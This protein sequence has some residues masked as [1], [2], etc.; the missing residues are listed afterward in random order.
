VPKP[1]R[2]CA[3]REV[4]WVIPLC[5]FDGLEAE[6]PFFQMADINYFAFAIV[7]HLVQK[8]KGA[9]RELIIEYAG[10][11]ALERRI[12]HDRV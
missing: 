9:I 3:R 12:T 8:R 7:P 11:I 10:P 1:A 4:F 6:Q 2:A 5:T